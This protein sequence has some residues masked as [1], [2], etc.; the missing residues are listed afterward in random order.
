MRPRWILRLGLWLYDHLARRTV[1]PASQALA[2]RDSPLGAGLKPEFVRGFAYFDCWVDDARLVVANCIDAARRG[3]TVCTRTRVL[4]AARDGG[5]WRVAVSGPGG[6]GEYHARALVNATGPWVR[7]VLAAVSGAEPKH[8]IRLVKGSHIVTPRLYDGSHAFILQNDDGRVILVIPYRGRYSLIGTTDIAHTGR[9]EDAI[10]SAEEIAYLC[11]AVN[12]YFRRPIGSSDVLWSFS[13]VRPLYDDGSANPSEVTRDYKLVVDGHGRDAPL[14]SIYGG[15]ITTYRRLAEQALQRL[16]PWFPQLGAQWTG[17]A[18]LP[19]GEFKGGPATI[20]AA[21][22][23]QYPEL[24]RPLLEALASRHG[25][26]ARNV[27]GDACTLSD[28]GAH[29]GE[30]LYAREVDYLVAYEWAQSADDILWRRT[31]AGL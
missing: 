24:P 18:P 23:S 9:P 14:L 7:S 21:L 13:G 30:S 31:K 11:A 3:A 6:R 12:R 29:F 1:L 16:R 10:I 4:A 26:A 19:G 5:R 8:R 27:L 22:A 20:A 28:L 15:K 2:L 25:M 17:H